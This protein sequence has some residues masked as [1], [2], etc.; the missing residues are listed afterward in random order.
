[1]SETRKKKVKINNVIY[2]SLKDASESLGINKTTLSR[3]I[4]NNK[5]GYETYKE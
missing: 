2:D 3:W 4:K 5:L 1:M